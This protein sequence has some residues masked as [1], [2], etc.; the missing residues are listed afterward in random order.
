MDYATALRILDQTVGESVSARFPGRLDRMRMLLAELDHPERAFRSIH[1]GGTAGKG[2]TATMCAAILHAAGYKVG[3][4]TKP[5]LHAVTE[6]MRINGVPISPQRFADLFTAFPPILDKMRAGEWGPPSYFEI[7]VAM[8]FLYFAQERVDAAVVEVGVGGTLD[9]TNVLL[10]EVSVLT[11]VGTD[12]RDV[13]GDTVEQIARD[14]AGII[15]DG[16]PVVTAAEQPEVLAI[17]HAAAAKHKAPLTVVQQ[18]VQMTDTVTEGGFAQS[19]DL[20][21]PDGRY[22][23]VLPLIGEFQAVNAATAIVA[24]ERVRHVWPLQPADVERGLSGVALAGRAEY[25]PSHPPLLFDVAHNVEKMAALRSALERHFPGRRLTIVAAIAEDKDAP[26]MLAVWRGSPAHFIFTAFEVAHRR[27]R[28]PQHLVN[29]ASSVGLS[30]RAVD[31]P[32]EALSIARRVAGPSD[33]VVVTGSTFLVGDVR[34]WF[35]ENT[36]APGPTHA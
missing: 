11:N 14:K 7:L 36:P 17:L 35:L 1:V 33:L 16:I 24:C 25:C 26:A 3:L 12:H 15:K 2:S 19:I 23:F 13:L 18:T 6:R 9:G 27:S 28:H 5:H 10:P 30:A 22:A 29:V 21:T 32:I 8:S 20:L 34:K 4:H 31:D